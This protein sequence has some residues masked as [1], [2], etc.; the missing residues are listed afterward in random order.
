[1]FGK[2]NFNIKSSWSKLIS[3]RR[4]T[5]L[6]FPLSKNSLAWLKSTWW[7]GWFPRWRPWRW[8]SCSRQQLGLL[9]SRKGRGP[10]FQRPQ[11]TREWRG[12]WW[13]LSASSVNVI[14][15]LFNA[16][17]NKLEQVMAAFVSVWT[18]QCWARW[19][20]INSDQM[21]IF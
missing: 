3:T 2:K 18:I 21:P 11:S 14:R 17:H 20:K 7:Q 8:W 16:W 10:S 13:C 19:I 6:S 1:M 12:G 9:S 4:S 5:V 15:T